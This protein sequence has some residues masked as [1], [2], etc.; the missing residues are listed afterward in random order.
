MKF[1]KRKIQYTAYITSPVK[2]YL[3]FNILFVIIFFQKSFGQ[4]ILW[5]FIF[6]SVHII[7]NNA[8]RPSSLTFASILMK[9]SNALEKDSTHIGCKL[10][11]PY[12]FASTPV[13]KGNTAVPI[14]PKQEIQPIEPGRSQRGMIDPH[15]L[16]MMG[17][18]GPKSS[19]TRA[20]A[21]ASPISDGTNHII[22]SR[23][24]RV[25]S[26]DPSWVKE[27]QI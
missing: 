13:M 19:P 21:T 8:N 25:R 2:R 24:C 14:I 1:R 7:I 26:M 11:T 9:S 16:M 6:T 4:S 12:L 5:V 27:E 17:N 23:L 3:I 22:I 10:M 18:I 15:W 20:M